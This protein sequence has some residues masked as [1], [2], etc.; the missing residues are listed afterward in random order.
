MAESRVASR[1]ARPLLELAQQQGVL[2]EVHSDMQLFTRTVNEH[3]DLKLA[4]Q[5]PIIKNDKKLA[6][7]NKVFGNRIHPMT[8][9][10]FRIISQKNRENILEDIAREFEHQYNQLKGIQVAH[11]TTAVPLAP[12]LRGEFAQVVAEQTGKIVQLKE[13]V[14]PELIGGYVLRVGDRQLDDSVRNSLRRLKN[15][16]KENPYISKL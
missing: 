11:V 2:P 8:A 16:F 6:I 7:L 5:N 14:D 10:I 9:T 13:H 3:R 12:Q 15:Q 1:Y 4:L